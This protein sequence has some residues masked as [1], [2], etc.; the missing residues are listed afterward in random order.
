MTV[1]RKFTILHFCLDMNG[2][3]RELVALSGQQG[4][5]KLLL[6]MIIRRSADPLART[7]ARQLF[8]GRPSSSAPAV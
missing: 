3:D 5:V 8:E 2:L 7:R 4:P 6:T 1:H